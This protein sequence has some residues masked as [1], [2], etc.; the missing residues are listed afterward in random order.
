ML[1]RGTRL[2]TFEITSHIGS[3]GMGDV[4][5]AHDSKL[6]RDVA[7]KVLPEQFARDSE[8]LARF[9]REAKLLAALNHPNIAAI[10]GLEQSGSTHYLVMELVPGQTLRERVAG[11][12]AVPVEEALTIARQ[13]AEALEAAH[14]SEKVIIH[15]DLKPAN[16]KVT[17][18][19]RVKVLD[20]G[21]A[22]AFAAEISPEDMAN[23]PTLS[24]APTM[25]GMIMGTAAYMS[26]EQA[27]GRHVNKAT[28][29]WA[30]GVVLYELLTGKQAFQG[31]DVADI[32]ATVVKMEP[33][34]KLLPEA[35]PPA[36]RTLLRRCLRKD[37]RQ[38]LQ[39]A[40]DARIEI[41][42]GLAWI[43]EGGSQAVPQG[44]T[45]AAVP[46]RKSRERLLAAVAAIAI[47]LAAAGWGAF[48][49]FRPAPE[50]AGSVRLLVSP[51]A[52][53]NLAQRIG[54][55]LAP[56]PISV[57]PDGRRV[58]FVALDSSGRSLIWIRSMDSL[59]AQSLT[60]TEDGY[61]PFWSPDSR[62]LGFFAGGRL[63]KI[64]VAGG[65]PVTLCD[66]P[67]GVGGTWNQD[68]LIVFTPTNTTTALLKVSSAG[69]EP[70][71]ATELEQ[72][73]TRHNRPF[74]LPDGEHFLF[75]A[76]GGPGEVR[77]Y[78]ASLGSTERTFL[79]NA[80]STN[81]VYSQGHLLFLRETTLMAQPFDAQRLELTG[82]PFPI[83]EQIQLPPVVSGSGLF[84]A[85]VNG[86]LAY[87][88][89]ESVA[90]SQLTWFDRTGKPIGVLGESA[91]YGDV[92]LAGD[93][94][95]ATVSIPNPSSQAGRDL[96]VYDVARG[97]KTRFTSDPAAEQNSIW[98]PD[99]S[100]V[101]FNS[102]RK[103]RLDMY[104]KDSSGAGIEEVLVED[105]V[106]KFPTA[107]TPDGRSILYVRATGPTGTGRDLF[108]L[109]LS[110][111]RK[112]V[113]FLETPFVEN[114]AQISP[115][116][117][118]VSFTS[119]ESG[120][121]EIHVAPFPGPG[122]R[123]LISTAGGAQARWRPDGAEIFYL[124]PDNKLM[125]AEVNGRGSSFEVGAVK[126][127]FQTSAVLGSRRAYDVSAD[128]QRFLINTAPEQAAS[129]PITVV[130]NWTA[131]LGK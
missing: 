91:L 3:G 40:I 125:V 26:P 112:S 107:W 82:D 23:S 130:V 33:D 84:S 121:E 66:A 15:R 41:D 45:A 51:P 17:P 4:Y 83:A 85:S 71:A 24:A 109:P 12:K 32:L 56:A 96:W 28:D 99:G 128:G 44:G 108:V 31:E 105:N 126:P 70:T 1:N 102:R 46:Q 63:K 55:I 111:D 34:W 116:G 9:Q 100:R 75:T 103:G 80:D 127:L 60:G 43:A 39:D 74:F 122:G 124:A 38:R 90:G 10:Y 67:L 6:D 42:D 113:P 129:A 101:V 35:T 81:V 19:G 22:K 57:S 118:W 47:V 78:V 65:P 87:Q 20:F 2:G 114:Y 94:K 59:S 21:L 30:F 86:V 5:Q 37:R 89:G 110:G 72:G 13:I 92:E 120:R 52:G 49:Y 16:V 93:G 104:Q 115:D 48:A 50:E 76:V 77:A 64:D 18:E 8:R 73:E 106:D 58:A 27:R 95:W 53:W 119:N 123:R 29:I 7:I 54:G 131:G 25:Q 62:F 69:G 11:E 79:F 36:I 97:L 61:A 68:G 14:N 98:S 117:R 88:T